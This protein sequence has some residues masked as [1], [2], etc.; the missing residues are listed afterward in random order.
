M[1]GTTELKGGLYILNQPQVTI[2]CKPPSSTNAFVNSL[3]LKH[4][5]CNN[6]VNH[7]T[8]THDDHCNIWYLS[9]LS[10]T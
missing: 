6:H 2:P 3:F 9:R 8:I 7:N 4:N 10:F 1:V 5:T